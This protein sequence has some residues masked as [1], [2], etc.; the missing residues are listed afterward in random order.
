[1][2]AL[3]RALAS[4]STPNSACPGAPPNSAQ[5]LACNTPPMAAARRDRSHNMVLSPAMPVA[6]AIV[7]PAADTASSASAANISCTRPKATPPDNAASSV[8]IP[9]AQRRTGDATAKAISEA[10]A[11]R[12]CSLYVPKSAST[13]RQTY[14][15]TTVPSIVRVPG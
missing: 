8:A 2:V 3:S 11:I 6:T 14:R 15:P 7:N 9:L 12:T 10:G 13:S 1:M 5:P 4:G